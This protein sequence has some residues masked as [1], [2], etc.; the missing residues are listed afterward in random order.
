MSELDFRI[1]RSVLEMMK[2]EIKITKAGLA[3]MSGVDRKTIY[4]KIEKYTFQDLQKK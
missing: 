4:N 3:R 2:N 1:Y